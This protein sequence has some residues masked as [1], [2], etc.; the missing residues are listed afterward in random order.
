MSPQALGGVSSGHR[1]ATEIL[2]LQLTHCAV[3]SPAT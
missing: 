1:V 2:E 3:H